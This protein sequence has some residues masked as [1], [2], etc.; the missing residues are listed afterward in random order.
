[1][2][3]SDAFKTSRNRPTPQLWRDFATTVTLPPDNCDP[4]APQL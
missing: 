4:T 1:M 3:P 2:N